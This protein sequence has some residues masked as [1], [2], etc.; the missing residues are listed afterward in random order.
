MLCG[1]AW[2]RRPLHSARESFAREEARK[3]AAFSLD[4]LNLISGSRVLNTKGHRMWALV[5]SL[6][7]QLA[8][9]RAP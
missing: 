9:L 7:Q 5:I 3:R 6:L 1:N 4:G 2:E 8:H